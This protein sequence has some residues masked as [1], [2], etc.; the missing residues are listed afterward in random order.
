M[1]PVLGGKTIKCQQH[2]AV[3]FETLDGLVIFAAMGRE[4]INRR[5]SRRRPSSPTSRYR[6]DAPW[7]WLAGFWA[8]CSARRRSCEPS[9]VVPEPAREPG[10]GPSKIPVRRHPPLVP[11]TVQGCAVSGQAEVLSSFARFHDNHPSNQ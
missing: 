10:A 2:I 7:P 5:L 11:D 3:L 4:V 8:S 1:L 6:A 9:N